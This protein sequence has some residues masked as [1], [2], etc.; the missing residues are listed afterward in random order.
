MVC[1]FTVTRVFTTFS[2]LLSR[3]GWSVCGEMSKEVAMQM[4]VEELQ[5]VS[6]NVCVW[7][8]G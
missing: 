4:Y 7:N 2:S 3:E 6:S 5:R 8:W 1:E